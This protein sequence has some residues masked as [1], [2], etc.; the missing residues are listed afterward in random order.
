[1]ILFLDF[2][3]VLHPI[4]TEDR[5]MLCHVPRLESVLH[6]FPH[7]QVV[8][9]SWWRASHT[10]DELREYFSEDIRHRIIDVTPLQTERVPGSLF[11]AAAKERGEEVLQWIESNSYG[12][13]WVALDDDHLGFPEFCMQ[14][15]RCH[16]EKGFD[17][18]AELRLVRYLTEHE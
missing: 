13:K 7:V 2:D 11:L 16:T 8:I 14:L 12:G 17:Q 6:A 5:N 10:L 4:P 18:D 1:M 9:S 15:I 3:G